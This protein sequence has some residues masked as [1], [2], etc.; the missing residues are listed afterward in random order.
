M[1]SSRRAGM[2]RPSMREQKSVFGSQEAA[3]I[4]A[5]ND[6]LSCNVTPSMTPP[7]IRTSFTVAVVWRSIPSCSQETL[8]ASVMEL[9]PPVAV[10]PLSISWRSS[11]AF[12]AGDQGPVEE[13]VRAGPASRQLSSWVSNHSLSQSATHI[14][15]IRNTSIMSLRPSRRRVRPVEASAS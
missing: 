2:C 4:G 9:D 10:R 6:S 1:R 12:V 13:Q 11:M 7:V 15:P 14:G 3:T 8:S 5:S